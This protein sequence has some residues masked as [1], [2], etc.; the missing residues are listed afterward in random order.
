MRTDGRGPSELR[1]VIIQAGY[2]AHP[3]GSCLVEFGKTKVVCSAMLEDRVPPF[4]KGTGQGWVTAEYGMLPGSTEQRT[5]REASRGKQ[6]GRT[7]EIQRLIGRSLRSV[8]D[9]TAFPDKTIWVDC[10]VLQADGGTRTAA[11]TGSFVAVA[12]AFHSLF[13]AKVI[14]SFPMKHLVAAVSVGM[15]QGERILDLKYDEDSIAEVDMN[16]VMTDDGRFI[17]VQGTA[18][19]APFTKADLDGLLALAAQGMDKLF[20]YQRSAFPFDLTQYGL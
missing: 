14:K 6:S 15:L 17:E 4:I 16:I 18:E 10:D 19:H 5:Q 12:M 2:L 9:F 20:A 3:E 11:I 1:P 13:E 8:T 7:L